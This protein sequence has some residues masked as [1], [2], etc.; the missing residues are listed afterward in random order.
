MGFF[1][2]IAII[3]CR[4]S[5]ENLNEYEKCIHKR[6][7]VRCINALMDFLNKKRDELKNQYAD[8]GKDAW[9]SFYQNIF[10]ITWS[11]EFARTITIVQIKKKFQSVICKYIDYQI[12]TKQMEEKNKA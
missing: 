10:K 2:N 1:L 3:E 12:R 8:C 11:F 9:D 4:L 7:D 6:K 5:T